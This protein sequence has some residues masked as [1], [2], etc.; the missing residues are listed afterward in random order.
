MES[1][2]IQNEKGQVGYL[3]V[4]D[5]FEHH[6]THETMRKVRFEQIGISGRGVVEETCINE[7]QFKDLYNKR[8]IPM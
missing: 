1:F 3:T 7:T 5:S 6:Y 2:E 8:I 4:I